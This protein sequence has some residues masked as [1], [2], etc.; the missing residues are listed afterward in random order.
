[1]TLLHAVLCSNRRVDRTLCI[2]GTSGVHCTYAGACSSKP[3]G[4]AAARLQVGHLTAE[5]VLC[6]PAVCFA[7]IFGRRL[8]GV[9][10]STRA[11]HSSCKGRWSSRCRT[12]KKSLR[13]CWRSSTCEWGG[14][15]C[16]K[17]GA[18]SCAHRTWNRSG[19]PSQLSETGEKG[20]QSV[21]ID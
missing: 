21:T 1:M 5:A 7:G 4:H 9:F 16:D 12:W 20:Q 13:L 3:R 15:T 18:T 10:V 6:Y 19:R 2:L 11:P 8:R 14:S 17:V